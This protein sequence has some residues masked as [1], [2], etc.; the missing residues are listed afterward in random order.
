MKH[1]FPFQG[2]ENEVRRRFVVRNQHSL[3]HCHEHVLRLV[4]AVNHQRMEST[5]LIIHLICQIENF[6]FL[7]CVHHWNHPFLFH[8]SSVSSD[9]FICK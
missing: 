7:N 6:V 9:F 5:V 2:L 4:I 8:W 3:I 1:R